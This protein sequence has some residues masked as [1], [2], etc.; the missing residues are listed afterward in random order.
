MQRMSQ[1][2]EADGKKESEGCGCG[3]A[4]Q[5]GLA[6][7]PGVQVQALAHPSRGSSARG[8]GGRG[9]R[10][11]G[12]YGTVLEVPGASALELAALSRL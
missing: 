10:G 4:V 6:A 7:M 9:W 5:A 2:S 12:G 1:D 8:R 3:C 11:L